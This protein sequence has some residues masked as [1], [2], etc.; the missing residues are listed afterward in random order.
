MAALILKG[1]VGELVA[2][3]GVG[4]GSGSWVAIASMVSVSWETIAS[5][6]SA[7]GSAS[8][9]GLNL[10]AVVVNWRMGTEA[11]LSG[12]IPTGGSDGPCLLWGVW[13]Q[14]PSMWLFPCCGFGR[15]AASVS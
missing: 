14:S 3:A 13:V 2:D 15:V 8:A 7:I 9:I 5:L 6:V 12:V 10:L 1:P 4:S 11:P